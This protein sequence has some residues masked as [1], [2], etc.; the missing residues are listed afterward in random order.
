MACYEWSLIS[1]SSYTTTRIR[2]FF[3]RW[4]GVVKLFI[5]LFI[6]LSKDG[7]VKFV[8]KVLKLSDQIEICQP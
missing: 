3:R 8:L 6:Y 5:Y 2:S 7:V 1:I 4:A